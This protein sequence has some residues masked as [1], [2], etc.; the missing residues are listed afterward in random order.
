[1]RPALEDQ[2]STDVDGDG[3]ACRA[4]Y[5]TQP[6][7]IAPMLKV[8]RDHS[9][10]LELR[11]VGVEG[12]YRGRVLDLGKGHFLLED[13]RPRDGLAHLRRG[14]RFSFAARVEDLYICGEDC[15]VTR[16]ESERGLPY[17]RAD[18]PK[19]LL[20]HRRRRHARIT[21]PP[22][23]RP[24]EGSIW[25]T[26]EHA[27]ADLQCRIIDISVGGARIAF[28]G[29][30]LPS[31]QSD[32]VLPNCQLRVSQSL[33]FESSAVIRHTAWDA[34]Q[35][36]TVCGIEFTGMTVGDRRRLEHYVSQLTARPQKS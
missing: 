31:L 34:A 15:R 1:M 35:R 22:R 6:D 14:A 30:I 8:L 21:L 18:L 29:A 25:V 19:R 9:A 24:D 23:V 4:V 5:L 17:F 33:A 2:T 11:L 26:R 28:N 36:M 13:I 12:H 32:E 7:D 16:V 27:S 3:A 10:V 20:R